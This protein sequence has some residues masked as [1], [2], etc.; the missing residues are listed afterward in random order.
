LVKVHG[1]YVLHC[2]EEVF[3]ETQRAE[4]QRAEAQMA[5]LVLR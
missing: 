4:A 5:G 3:S 2:L 1:I